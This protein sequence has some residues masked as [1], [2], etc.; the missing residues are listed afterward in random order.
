MRKI[1]FS[2]VGCIWKTKKTFQLFEK[3]IKHR[4]ILRPTITNK[5]TKER[6]NRTYT[7]GCV[8]GRYFLYFMGIFD[9]VHHKNG[10][11]LY[12]NEYVQHN[13]LRIVGNGLQ[14]KVFKT[15][16]SRENIFYIIL[17]GHLVFKTFIRIKVRSPFSHCDV[18]SFV[19]SIRL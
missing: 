17:W 16:Y 3:W 11:H 8:Y 9:N 19:R 10:P 1:V 14:G 5:I 4:C 7:F 15:V 2:R 18:R 13:L 12:R 6:A